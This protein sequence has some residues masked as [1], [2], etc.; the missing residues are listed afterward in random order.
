[1]LVTC[2]SCQTDN[3]VVDRVGFRDSCTKCFADLHVC[4]NCQFYD[5]KA[6]NECLEPAADRVKDKEKSNFCEFFQP[7]VSGNGANGKK[8]PTKEDLRAQAEALFS[9]LNKKNVT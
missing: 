3:T 6:Y 5:E 9:N 1:M 4:N 7:K 8:V 2:F